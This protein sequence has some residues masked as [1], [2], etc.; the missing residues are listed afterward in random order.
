MTDKSRQLE[1][2]YKSRINRTFDYIESNLEKQFTLEELASVANF[3]KFHFHRIFQGMVGETPFQFIMR[4]RLEKAAYMLVANPNES[5]TEIAMKCGFADLSVFS[6]NF[7][8]FFSKSA[9]RWRKDKQALSN[10]GKAISNKAQDEN[11]AFMYFCSE[12]KTIKWRTNMKQNRSMEVK[13]LPGMTVAYIRHTGPYQG[14]DKL[15]ENLW[16]RL[17]SWAG[18]RGLLQQPD[19]RSLIVYHDDPNITTPDKL[20][21]SVCITVSPET[22]VDGE[23]GKMEIDKGTYAIARFV[24]NS[25]E[26]QQAWDWVFGQWFPSSGYQP[27]DGPCFEIYPEKPENGKFTVDICVPVKPL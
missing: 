26:F 21:L 19:L 16:N 14:D 5:I 3:S 17:F 24:I 10:I 18:P 20:R 22:K 4:I 9:T 15:F 2:E 1:R 23:I 7:S 25:T 13:D 11:K 12:T 8:T 27:A 6:R